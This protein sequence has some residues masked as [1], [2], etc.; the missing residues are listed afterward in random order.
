MFCILSRRSGR[1]PSHSSPSDLR[2]FC[3]TFCGFFGLGGPRGRGTGGDGKNPSDAMSTKANATE[4]SPLLFP[5]TGRRRHRLRSFPSQAATS[6]PCAS[7][8]LAT[9]TG[10]PHGCLDAFFA[11][12]CTTCLRYF[13]CRMCIN[14]IQ[15]GPQII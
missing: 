2:I 12:N 5:N 15:F 14:N 8:F 3:N 6:K 13:A 9:S 11:T 4:E 7:S 10:S 1:S